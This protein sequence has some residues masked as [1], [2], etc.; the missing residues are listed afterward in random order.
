MKYSIL[1]LIFLT[2]SCNNTEEKKL[3]ITKKGNPKYGALIPYK[4][5]DDPEPHHT[6]DIK[7]TLTLDGWKIEYLVKN[8]STMHKDLYIQ[9]SKSNSKKTYRGHNI[10]QLQSYFTPVFKQETKDYI[11][12]QFEVRGGDGLLILPKDKTSPEL[13]FTYVI[14]YSAKYGQVAY[15]PETSYSNDHLDVEAYDLKTGKTKSVRFNKPCSVLP[16]NI[17]LLET[18]FDGKQIKIVGNDDGSEAGKEVR[19]IMF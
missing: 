7:D 1:L 17:C 12:M 19:T 10:L 9:W 8:D 15:I 18:T 2:V 5:K 14:G 4:E 3:V 11:F 16:E 13:T 6:R